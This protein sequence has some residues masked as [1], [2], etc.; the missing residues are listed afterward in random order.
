MAIH[1]NRLNGG[2]I[3]IG[4]AG[5]GGAS[6]HHDTWYKYAGDSDWRTISISNS[7]DGA[8]EDVPTN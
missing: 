6:E 3:T 1:I 2:N 4:T 5:G 7:I 8:G